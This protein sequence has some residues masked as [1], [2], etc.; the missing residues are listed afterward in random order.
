LD[1]DRDQGDEPGTRQATSVNRDG[2]V[3]RSRGDDTL[4]E[5]D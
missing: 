2:N 1:Y 3:R 5:S 4:L